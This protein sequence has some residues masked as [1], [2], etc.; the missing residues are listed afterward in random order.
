MFPPECT[1]QYS[2]KKIIIPTGMH[3]PSSIFWADLTPFSPQDG[4]DELP[5]YQKDVTCADISTF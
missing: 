1:G 5:Y 2:D 3:G 4:C